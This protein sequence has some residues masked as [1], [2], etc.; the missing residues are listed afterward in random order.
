MSSPQSSLPEATAPDRA[1]ALKELA[2]LFLRLGT[3]AFGGPA[4]HIAM[5][6]DEVVRR[7]KWL[8]RDEFVDLLGA[9]NLIPGPNSTELAIHIGHRRGGWPGLV[10]A[11]VCFILPAFLI[12]GAIGWAYSRFGSLPRV[13]ALLYG[14]KAVIIAVVL[15]ALWGLLRNVVKTRLAAAVG[16]VS[17]TAAFLGVHELLL[18]LLAGL[19]V[20]LWRAGERSRRRPP[21][22]PLAQDPVPARAATREA[23]PAS[24][25]GSGSTTAAVLPLWPVV[26][27][28]GALATAVP[29][30]L[31]GLFLFFVKVGSVLYGSGYVLLAFLRSDLVE[32]Y[33]WLTEAQLLDAVAVGQVT[34]GPVFT[35]ATFIG[36]VL[37]GASG[38]VLATVG[39]FLPA[40]IFV[41]L[42]GP[43][44]PRLR[45]SW[46]AGA[47]L[48][49]V[50]V[51]SLALMAVVTWQLG[52]AA[53]VDA[54]TVGLAA[55][56]A[57]LLI[58]FR[59]N[60]AWL[61]LGGGAVGMLLAR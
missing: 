39:I 53:L 59:V 30:S 52:R 31:S 60:S 38:A 61:V 25:G 7:R 37:G 24:P 8:T 12:V 2:L 16:V 44:V 27:V 58:R 49:G 23:P 54:W 51:A 14:V 48:D 9:A 33:G 26:P 15:Q 36:Y 11:G 47:F 18:L 1:T 20:L 21:G 35:T 41:A 55:V 32:R 22:P 6:E 5:M 56:S 57:V 10:V 29:F 43:L 46:V 3:T 28:T 34:P 4:A 50:N 17:V 40:F 42:S 13:D 19:A 45:R